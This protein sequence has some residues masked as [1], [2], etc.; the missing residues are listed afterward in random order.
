VKLLTGGNALPLLSA[1]D[2][3]ATVG[4]RVDDNPSWP[5]SVEWPLTR[6]CIECQT[7]FGRRRA[8]GRLREPKRWRRA[9]YC[10]RVCAGQR[11]GR[12]KA[13]PLAGLDPAL[14]P[15]QKRMRARPPGRPSH[16]TGREAIERVD[17]IAKILSLRAKG[18]T[19]REIG[20]R[21]TPPVTMQAV[22]R[23]FW[24]AMRSHPFDPARLR[25]RAARERETSLT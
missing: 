4:T 8:S 24:K 21:L 13:L 6:V 19:F 1:R 18:L 7:E 12:W 14:P 10:S 22:H 11:R 17:R 2:C 25:R 16:K 5:G 9:L 20:Q 3:P 23:T 15:R